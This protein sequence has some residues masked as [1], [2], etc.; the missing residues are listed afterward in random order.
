M[1]PRLRSLRAI[2][3]SPLLDAGP[4]PAELAY[5]ETQ[6]LRQPYTAP[7]RP[8]SE[9]ELFARIEH[10]GHW[11]YIPLETHLSQKAAARA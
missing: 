5:W 11:V 3:H 6:V 7:T 2:Q 9:N 8:G 10:D 4:T 1:R